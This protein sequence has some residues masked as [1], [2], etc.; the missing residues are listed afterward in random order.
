MTGFEQRHRVFADDD[1]V[2][3][4]D[5]D[6][7]DECDQRDD[8]DAVT[9]DAVEHRETEQETRR[10]ADGHPQRNAAIEEHQHGHHDE[11]QPGPR[12]VRNHLQLRAEQFPDVVVNGQL[13]AGR[14]VRA[15]LLEP[16]FRYAT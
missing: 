11:Q 7:H 16:A 13:H 6:R 14:E 12:V 15:R 1:R 3:H 4:H 9:E 2:V 8:A 10:H 5:A